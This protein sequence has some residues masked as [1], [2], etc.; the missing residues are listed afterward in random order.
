MGPKKLQLQ[1]AYTSIQPELLSVQEKISE[2]FQSADLHVAPILEKLSAQQGKMLRPALVLLS[3][4]LVSDLSPAHID[5][6]A[7]VELIHMASLLHDDVI[8]KSHLRRGNPSANALWGNTVAVLLGDFL[9]CRAF[10]LASDQNINNAA[11]TLAQTAQMLCSG[12]IKQN[13][14]KGRWDINE[15]DYF[16]IIEAK[17]AALFQ[18]SCR[19]GAEA[20][21]ASEQQVLSAGEFGLRFGIAF[22]VADDLRDV[23]STERNEG[24]TLGTDW[25]EGKLTLPVIHWIYQDSDQVQGRITQLKTNNSAWLTEQLRL[26]GSIDYAL[27][28]IQRNMSKARECLDIFNPTPSKDALLALTNHIANGLS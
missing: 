18:C 13:I 23:L 28:C 9:L 12:E 17:T 7:I 10:T 6:A 22:Q 25:L 15:Q 24:K 26:S 5:L 8:D 19:L 11:E 20:S 3:G 1:D 21:G 2:Q 14:L 16:Q 27:Q 4:K